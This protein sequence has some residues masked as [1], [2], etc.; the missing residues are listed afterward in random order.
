LNTDIAA[1]KEEKIVSKREE[2]KESLKT[3]MKARDEP[4]VSTLRLVLSSIKDKDIAA[5]GT[6]NMDGIGDGEIASLL[7]SM[8]KQRQESAKIF[9]DAGRTDLSEKEEAEIAIIT[10]YL[11]KQLSDSEM[12]AAVANAVKE[13]GA[14]GIKDMGKVM[15]ALKSRHAGQ[16]DMAKAG[17]MV[18]KA[19]RSGG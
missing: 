11:P 1:R 8:V 2:L 7:Q 17:D 3:A 13:S 5:R 16:M 15:G 6:G 19:L 14:A 18:K 4:V 12:E 9:K 10:G